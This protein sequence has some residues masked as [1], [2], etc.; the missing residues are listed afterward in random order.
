[1]LIGPLFQVFSDE[2]RAPGSP[3]IVNVCPALVKRSTP[4][5][6]IW[7]IHYTFPIHCNK[8]TVNFNRTDILCIQKPNYGALHNRRNY[9]FSYSLLNIS[10][11][12]RNR[13]SA[14]FTSLVTKCYWSPLTLKW[15]TSLTSS[16]VCK[17]SL[18]SG[19]P[20]YVREYI[21][22]PV[23]AYQCFKILS[24]FFGV[25]SISASSTCNQFTTIPL[26][27]SKHTGLYTSGTL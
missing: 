5:S 3:L 17:R 4:F 1:V 12:S 27:Q 18:L 13:I 14:S 11:K 6:H 7:L 15:C 8:L 24:L 21:S 10:K 20:L 23:S 16:A 25:G 22:N 9:R 26:R 19:W 2:R